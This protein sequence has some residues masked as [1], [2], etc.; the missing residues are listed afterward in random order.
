MTIQRLNLIVISVVGVV[1]L[2]TAVLATSILSAYQS[3]PNV[4]TVKSV[5]VGVYTNLECNESVTLINWGI[6]GPG[7]KANFIIYV[8]NEGNILLKLNI[9]TSK[10]VPEIA[11]AYIVFEWDPRGRILNPSEVVPVTLTLSVSPDI[12]GVTSFQFEIL[13]VGIEV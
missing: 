9:T 6:L 3:I 13:V 11:S 2:F 7:D 1:G 5:G 10:W 8:R 4:G 12:E